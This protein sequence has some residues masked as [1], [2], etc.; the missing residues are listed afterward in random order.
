MVRIPMQCAFAVLST[1]MIS[2]VASFVA[3]I[4]TTSSAAAKTQCSLLGGVKYK[5]AQ[6]EGGTKTFAI[7]QSN[8]YE[9][10]KR[11]Q[12]DR[13]VKSTNEI[14]STSNT[15]LELAK[16]SYNIL[17]Q[18]DLKL[19]DGFDGAS[20]GWTSWVEV[21]SSKQ[22]HNF[23]DQLIFSTAGPSKSNSGIRNTTTTITSSND[24]KWMKWLKQITP[25]PIIIDL[26]KEFRN[27]ANLTIQE[28]D[29]KVK[30]MY[31][32]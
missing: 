24:I 13:N 12:E 30:H 3:P 32:G 7:K 23:M 14:I 26:S 19:N 6:N 20:T 31:H 17:L 18:S 2:L 16:Y 21:N 29:L 28:D 11:S 5:S 10:K 9:Q 27:A 4:T 8:T 15:F 25:K 22:L 1:L